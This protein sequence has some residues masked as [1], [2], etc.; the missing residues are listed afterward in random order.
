MLDRTDE[1]FNFEWRAGSGRAVSHCI[2]KRVG[3]EAKV[4]WRVGK[5]LG[6]GNGVKMNCEELQKN[7]L[8]NGK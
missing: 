3:K 2:E 1:L 5:L 8:S 6:N 4:S 7:L